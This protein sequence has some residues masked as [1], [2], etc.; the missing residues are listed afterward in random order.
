LGISKRPRQ[1]LLTQACTTLILH[2]LVVLAVSA[3]LVELVELVVLGDVLVALAVLTASTTA[4]TTVSTI[5]S[6]I[7]STIAEAIAAEDTI[8][9]A[10]AI[11]AEDTIAVAGVIVAAVDNYR[12][13]KRLHLE[14]ERR[15]A[16]AVFAGASSLQQLT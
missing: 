7:A 9:V 12:L 13:L 3:V 5:V 8:A 11:V 1:F 14:M 16:L 6:T 15:R 4:F 2:D 10:E